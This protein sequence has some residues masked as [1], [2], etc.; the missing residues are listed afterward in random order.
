MPGMADW[1][2]EANGQRKGLELQYDPSLKDKKVGGQFVE[3]TEN[4][5]GILKYT[6]FTKQIADNY[7]QTIVHELAH[8]LEYNLNVTDLI[9]L[10][11][12]LLAR[13]KSQTTSTY[14]TSEKTYLAFDLWIPEDTQTAQEMHIDLH[15]LAYA[16]VANNAILDSKRSQGTEFLSTTAEFM[17]QINRAQGLINHDPMRVALFFYFAHPVIFRKIATKFAEKSNVRRLSPLS[18]EKLLHVDINTSQPPIAPPP[19][20]T[21]S[22][23]I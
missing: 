13:M 6:K 10:Y 11:R 8:K 17:S 14:D 12:H 22:C 7:I 18:L 16:C 15:K 23:R 9:L 5:D 3:D 4:L 19:L 2:N 1:R 21:T 20:S